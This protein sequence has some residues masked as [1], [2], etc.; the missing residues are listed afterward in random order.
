MV[1]ELTHYGWEPDYG[2]LLRL[3]RVMKRNAG[4]DDGDERVPGEDETHGCLP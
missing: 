3:Y 2:R 4:D 1:E